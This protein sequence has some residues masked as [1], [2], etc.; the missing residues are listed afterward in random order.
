MHLIKLFIIP[1]FLAAGCSTVNVAV[2]SS[3][4]FD[5][6][7]RHVEST[8]RVTPQ[9]DVKTPQKPANNTPEA[10]NESSNTAIPPECK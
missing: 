6:D 4:T 7:I 2:K 5:D 10:V 9:R 8:R 3:G 1:V